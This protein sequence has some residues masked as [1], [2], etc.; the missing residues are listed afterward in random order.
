MGK[1]KMCQN[2]EHCI[3]LCEGDFICDMDEPTLII[4]E[5]QPTKDYYNCGGVDFEEQE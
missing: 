5:W 3:Y 2:C 4:E 1:P